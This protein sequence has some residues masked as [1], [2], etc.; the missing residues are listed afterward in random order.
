MKPGRPRR[1]GQH[2]N[3]STLGA[4]RLGSPRVSA[5]KGFLSAYFVTDFDNQQAVLEDALIPAAPRQDQLASRSVAI[6][7]KGCRSR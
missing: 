7:G 4:E 2:V 5:D 1:R 3:H 6:A